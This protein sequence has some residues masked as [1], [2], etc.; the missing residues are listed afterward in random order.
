MRSTVELIHE[1]REE[2]VGSMLT[3]LVVGAQ[4]ATTYVWANDDNA[5]DI[6]NEAVRE[7]GEPVGFI[8]IGRSGG[9][10]NVGCW[11]LK[12][13]VGNSEI[14]DSLKELAV[15]IFFRFSELAQERTGT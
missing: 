1:L 12:E 8:S 10:L 3:A 15:G 6:L 11:P 14:E 5:L 4:D 2:A 9:N 7:G 13:Y